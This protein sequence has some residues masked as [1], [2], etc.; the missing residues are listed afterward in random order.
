MRKL[1]FMIVLLIALASVSP[2]VLKATVSAAKPGYTINNYIAINVPTIDGNWTTN[3][4]EDAEERELDGSLTVYFRLKYKLVSGTSYNYVLIDFL[5]DTTDDSSDGWSVYI[6]AHHD[7]GSTPQSDDYRISLTGHTF[8]G[9]HVYKGNGTGWVETTDFNWGPDLAIVNGINPS[10]HLST[11]HWICEFKIN[12]TWCN[13]LNDYTIRVAAYD[14]SGGGNQ[15]WPDSYGNVPD[16]WGQ[17]ITQFTTIPEFSSLLIP[18][19]LMATTAVAL[20]A[21]KRRRVP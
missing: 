20:L 18:L 16:D 1:A 19:M 21:C 17:T 4:W 3:E 11:P 14:A 12:A 8:P 5:N 13:L 10:P 2:A 9:L 15:V 7:G 6:D